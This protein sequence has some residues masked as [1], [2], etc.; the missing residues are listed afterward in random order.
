[1]ANTLFVYGKNTKFL[2]YFNNTPWPVTTKTWGVQEQCVEA[3]DG[4]NGEDRDRL[5]KITNYYTC[6]F[7]CYE[8]GSSNTLQNLIL[9]QQ[10]EDAQLPPLALSGGLLFTFPGIGGVRLGF[11]LS[12]CSMGPLDMKS[13]GRTSAFMHSLKFRAQYFNPVATAQLIAA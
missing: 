6:S 7:E 3:A 5:Q 1:M 10:N 11:T 8:D 12:G 4:V 2:V 9:N 13:A